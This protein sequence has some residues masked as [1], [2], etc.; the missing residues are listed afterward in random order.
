M[1]LVLVIACGSMRMPRLKGELEN[2]WQRCPL[3]A[4]PAQPP[5]PGL[6]LEQA[7]A[8]EDQRFFLFPEEA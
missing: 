2:V 1:T 3:A 4:H 7:I 6:R 5:R 8:P